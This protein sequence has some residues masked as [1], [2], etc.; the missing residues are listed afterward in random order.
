MTLTPDDAWT[1]WVTSA[2][3]AI[4]ILFIFID[5]PRRTK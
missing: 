5:Y 3:F 1:F 2:C 4:V